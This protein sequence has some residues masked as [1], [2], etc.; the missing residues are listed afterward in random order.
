MSTIH[1][2]VVIDPTATIGENVQLGAYV[3]IGPGCVI[4]DGVKLYTHVTVQENTRIGQNTVVHSHACLG[5][6]PQDLSYKGQPTF[7]TIGENCQIRELVT[8]HRASVEGQATRIGNGC[9]LMTVSHIGHDSHLGNHVIIAS[10]SVVAGHVEIQDHVFISGNCS[11]HQHCRVGAF[12]MLGGGSATRQDIPPFCKTNGFPAGLVGLNTVGMRR[13]NVPSTSR[14]ALKRAYKTLW[15]SNMQQSHAMATLKE[16][17][18]ATDPYVAQLIDF[19]DNSPRGV[20]GHVAK[21][22]RRGNFITEEVQD[23]DVMLPVS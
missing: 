8:I 14:M 9:L 7:L 1:P 16:S 17:E 12:S 23:T 19:M 15:L 2:S 18:D 13:Q 10:N 6:D 5:G 20:V 21:L 3:T 22:Q 4:E 11:I